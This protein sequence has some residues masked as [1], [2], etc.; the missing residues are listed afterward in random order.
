M[1]EEGTG[2]YK[3]QST[4]HQYNEV[5][6]FM[7][8][9]ISEGVDKAK[10]DYKRKMEYFYSNIGKFPYLYDE[11]FIAESLKIMHEVKDPT[12]RFQLHLYEFSSCVYRCT[13]KTT[14]YSVDESKIIF[15]GLGKLCDWSDLKLKFDSNLSNLILDSTTNEALNYFYIIGAVFGGLWDGAFIWNCNEI[16]NSEK[17]KIEK[18]NLMR[19]EMGN[20]FIRKG[21]KLT[22][23]GIMVYLPTWEEDQIVRRI[24]DVL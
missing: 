10:P 18:I 20:L 6:T 19:A 3:K 23:D 11:K 9:M 15:T 7:R 1:T 13:K 21:S 22:S 4:S 8:K 24:Q 14:K 5:S 16:T 17:P 2:D 12:R